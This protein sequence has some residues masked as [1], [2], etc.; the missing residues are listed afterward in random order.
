M[1]ALRR[2]VP[3]ASATVRATPRL[4]IHYG[5]MVPTPNE[6]RKPPKGGRVLK[7]TLIGSILRHCSSS[8]WAHNK[9]FLR[10]RYNPFDNIR[11]N[12]SSSLPCSSLSVTH[13]GQELRGVK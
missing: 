6:I 7:H 8:H 1:C 4:T 2:S 12:S 13:E 3:S 11:W 9:S 5:T 10:N